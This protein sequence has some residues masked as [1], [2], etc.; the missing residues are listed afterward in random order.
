M[1]SVGAASRQPAGFAFAVR[2][3]GPA[4]LTAFVNGIQKMSVADS[5]SS[6]LTG[7][8]SAGMAASMSGIFFDE[9]KLSGVP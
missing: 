4:A 5:S 8:G 3:A 2:G 7:S 6:A 1:V 9:F